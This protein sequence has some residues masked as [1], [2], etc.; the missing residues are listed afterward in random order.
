MPRNRV[1]LGVPRVIACIC[2]LRAVLPHAYRYYTFIRW[3]VCG[4][5]VL[6]VVRS[7]RR[8]RL[9]EGGA[10]ILIAG[11][12]NPFMPVHMAREAWMAVDIL[13][14]ICLLFS[15]AGLGTKYGQDD[16]P[17]QR[18]FLPPI[19][20]ELREAMFERYIESVLSMTRPTRW[21]AIL[22]VGLSSFVLSYVFS[23]LGAAYILAEL[24]VI[25]LPHLALYAFDVSVLCT[26]ISLYVIRDY[27][28]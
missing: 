10:F 2:L 15:I 16:P 13:G 28:S 11:L 25:T 24:D 9:A 23:F 18:I 14:G 6:E 12:F 21:R 4:I 8:G 17:S 26:V 22:K 20:I 27:W 3:L 5:G 19:L 7:R 1:L